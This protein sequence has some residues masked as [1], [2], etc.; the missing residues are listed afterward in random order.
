M[1]TFEIESQRLTLEEFQNLPQG[2]PFYE[3]E[4]GDLILMSSPTLEHQDIVGLL[5]A[6]LHAFLRKSRLGRIAME[7]DVYLPDGRVYIP[8][9]SF[10]EQENINRISPIDQK[11]HGAPTMVAE[12]VSNDAA[13]DRIHKF[14]VYFE[15]DVAWYWLVT[16]ALEIE[17]YHLTPQ[18]YVRTASI[19][20]GEVFRPR[21]F[22]GLEINLQGL[23][24]VSEE[25]PAESVE[26]P[27]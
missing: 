2:P 26:S 16:Q 8:D 18:G 12:I 21:V 10:V 22:P 17:E 20:A 4:Q 7:L 6:F 23:L 5:F 9:L 3:F 19:A 13:R 24:G 1:A 14:Q 27:N 25:V 11:I 15:N